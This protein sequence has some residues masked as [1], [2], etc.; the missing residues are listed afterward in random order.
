MRELRY[1]TVHEDL[2][3]AL[4]E[5]REP[6]ERLFDDWDDFGGEPPGQYNVFS[7]TYGT[8]LDVALT[9]PERTPGRE[10]LLKRALD[11]GE[12]MLTS[13][14]LWV[15]ELAIDAVA[16]R[17]DGHPDGRAFVD[18]LGG[19]ELRDWFA[20]Y[21]TPDR[22]RPRP[23]EIVDLWGVR[24]AISPLFPT[25][26]AHELPGISY[27]SEWA[28]FASLD[29]ARE[30]AEG[31]VML[32][33]YRTTHLWAVMRARQV[34]AAATT[35]DELA[36]R[37]AALLRDDGPEGRPAAHYRVIPPGERVWSMNRGNERHCRLWDDPWVADPLIPHREEI[38]AVLRGEAD[39][40]AVA[41]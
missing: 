27:P 10:Q 37:L 35:L 18:R 20:T 17:L 24:P 26:P 9:L 13:S 29:A 16:E 14:D 8:L 41:P 2:L 30:A 38:L 22:Q 32:A 1:R 33:A 15:Y 39:A 25:V 21:S 40:L 34:G 6:Y 4:P 23:D 3:T 12:A 5:L 28:D 31:T 11:F 36:V 7:D 19:T